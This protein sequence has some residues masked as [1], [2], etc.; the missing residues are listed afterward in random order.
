MTADTGEDL[1]KVRA[2]LK[3]YHPDR[4]RTAAESELYTKLSMHLNQKLTALR[5]NSGIKLTA[6]RR[7]LSQEDNE[8]YKWY[9]LGIE[10]YRQIDSDKS[11]AFE[12]AGQAFERVIHEY[13]LSVWSSDARD[14]LR[15]LKK[16]SESRAG[17]NRKRR[18]IISCRL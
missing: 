1:Q 9:K 16:L 4:A 11:S 6:S 2:L 12:A 3:K 15:L 13:P 10:H 5:Q 18:H 8:A 17:R 7:T 14:K